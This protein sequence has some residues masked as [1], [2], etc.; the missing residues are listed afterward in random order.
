MIFKHL[1][2]KNPCISNYNSN[3]N[4]MFCKKNVKC[5]KIDSE[6]LTNDSQM[7]HNDSQNLILTHK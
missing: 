4:Q 6:L 7:T 1:N 5:H 2:R 3:D